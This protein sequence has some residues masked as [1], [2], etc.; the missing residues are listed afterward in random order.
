MKYTFSKF[1]PIQNQLTGISGELLS[2][3]LFPRN[4]TKTV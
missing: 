4:G 3:Q 1:T 2:G